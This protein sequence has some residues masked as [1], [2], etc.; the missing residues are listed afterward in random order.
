LPEKRI[1]SEQELIELSNLQLDENDIGSLE[2][3]KE[4]IGKIGFFTGE[5]REGTVVNVI[6]SPVAYNASNLYRMSRAADATYVAFSSSVFKS[7]HI[8]GSYR[9]NSSQ[10]CINCYHSNKLKRCFEMDSCRSCSDSYFCHNCENLDSC[11]LC[12]NTKNKRYAVGNVE[13]GKEEFLRLKKLILGEIGAEIEA[14]K[15]C[16]LDIYNIGS[17]R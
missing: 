1:V 17:R 9:V 15:D 4:K 14:K 8:F 13:V 2:K 12:F 5:L 16:M 6:K 11:M 7:D 3:I 10:F